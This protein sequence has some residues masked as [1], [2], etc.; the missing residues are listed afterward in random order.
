MLLISNINIFICGEFGGI[1][2]SGGKGSKV[3]DNFENIDL[4]KISSTFF[5]IESKID[6]IL[7]CGERKNVI[8]I[9]SQL[10]NIYK[11]TDRGDTFTKINDS[12]QK[13]SKRD[14]TKFQTNIGTISR[15]VESEAD[16]ETIYFIG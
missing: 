8:F 10:K 14:M 11:S 4:K 9:L 12:F 6:N 7:W 13:A 3:N 1:S 15:I 5:E 2:V 16:P